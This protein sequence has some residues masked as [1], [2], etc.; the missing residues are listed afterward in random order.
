MHARIMSFII[1]GSIFALALAGQALA[2]P[3]DCQQRANLAQQMMMARQNGVTAVK[4]EQVFVNSLPAEKAAVFRPIIRALY[5]T[6]AYSSHEYK[7]K[8][9]REFGNKIYTMC[10]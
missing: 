7:L 1:H 6:P 9:A 2:A 5:Q 4:M 8:A 3:S 10:K